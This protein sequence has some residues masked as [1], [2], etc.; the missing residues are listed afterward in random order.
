MKFS[1]FDD[2]PVIITDIGLNTKY[3]KS[4][5]LIDDQSNVQ[6]NGSTVDF[7]KFQE[8]IQKHANEHGTGTELEK[9]VKKSVEKKV[10]TSLESTTSASVSPPQAPFLKVEQKV[11]A[12]AKNSSRTQTDNEE[13]EKVQQSSVRKDEQTETVSTNENVKNH[14]DT[15]EQTSTSSQW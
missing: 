12:G 15:K 5:A 6:N 3:T 7:N 13:N 2:N 14:W 4:D 11:T 10:E 9:K 1:N 8:D